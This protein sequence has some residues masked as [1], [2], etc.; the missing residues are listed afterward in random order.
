MSVERDHAPARTSAVEAVEQDALQL[1]DVRRTDLH[2]RF[3][4]IYQYALASELLHDLQRLQLDYDSF[5]E[6][7]EARSEGYSGWLY[8]LLYLKGYSQYRLNSHVDDENVYYRYLTRQYALQGDD[9]TLRAL[10][11]PSLAV[12]RILRRF[13]DCDHLSEPST[14]ARFAEQ[15]L[16]PVKVL[17]RNPPADEDTLR[18][19]RVGSEEPIQ[20]RLLDGHH[21]LF[22]A[23][24]F[25][26]KRIRFV[27]LYE[28]GTV[29]MVP[30]NVDHISLEGSRLR[31]SG[32]TA[33]P[34]A[35]VHCLEVR[36]R[37]RTLCRVPLTADG[38]TRTRESAR[39]F[40]FAVDA[41]IPILAD[42]LGALDL[43]V[44]EDWLPV[45]RVSV[46]S[47]SRAPE[48]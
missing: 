24:L 19:Y 37:G 26:V 27:A 14:S 3:F 18:I 39:R 44:L 32:W 9:P 4:N 28:S 17:V 45:G 41:D 8:W 38:E 10:S 43:M 31:M 1:L 13:A 15:E 36:V 30:G 20:A 5:S 25:G 47:M 35:N 29:S 11:T 6:S 48:L 42:D 34:S 22:A 33:P 46:F 16:V 23:R 7:R 2:S 21:R 12:E 40:S